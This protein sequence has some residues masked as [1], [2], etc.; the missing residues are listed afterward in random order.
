MMNIAIHCVCVNLPRALTYHNQHDRVIHHQAEP[1]P[2]IKNWYILLALVSYPDPDSHAT[3]AGG[4]AVG[5]L[6]LGTR[7]RQHTVLIFMRKLN[8]YS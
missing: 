1:S 4:A 3:A 2:F 7:L 8:D 5:N 6:G